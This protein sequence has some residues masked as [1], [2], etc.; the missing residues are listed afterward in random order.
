LIERGETWLMIP[1]YDDVLRYRRS[2]GKLLPLNVSK[3]AIGALREIYDAGYAVI[4]ASIDNL[5][6]D[7][8]EGLKLFDF[9]FSHRYQVQPENFEQ[10]FDVTG[11]P[12]DYSGDLPIQGG[13]SYDRNWKPYIGLTLNSLMYDSRRVQLAKRAVYAS[14]HFHRFV[15][16]LIRSAISRTMVRQ[17]R[18]D[19]FLPS[20]DA[21]TN[22][23]RRTTRAA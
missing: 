13:N 14:S 5:L 18:R 21:L 3:Q 17:V 9:E 7:R 8:R 19:P 11:C 16:R 15:P 23:D 2:S 12:V 4:D 20:D 6:V 1:F 10:S 22:E